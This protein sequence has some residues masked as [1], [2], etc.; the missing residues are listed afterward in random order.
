[1]EKNFL[2][3]LKVDIMIKNKIC[4]NTSEFD[5]KKSIILVCDSEAW[6]PFS[7]LSLFYSRF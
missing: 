7:P 2:V 3:I 1:M 4:K 5:C 6:I